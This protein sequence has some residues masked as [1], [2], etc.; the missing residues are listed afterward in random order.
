MYP[1]EDA[2]RPLAHATRN[3][4]NSNQ[5]CETGKIRTL[6]HAITIEV[7]SHSAIV[8]VLDEIWYLHKVYIH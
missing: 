3:C 4:K 8:A 6:N 2:K 5:S 1:S 7:R